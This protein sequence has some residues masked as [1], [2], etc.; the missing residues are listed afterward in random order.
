MKLKKIYI[1]GNY[2]RT[3]QCFDRFVD[4]ELTLRRTIK[5]VDVI[6][7]SRIFYQMPAA[8]QIQ[9]AKMSARLIEDSDFILIMDGSDE[10][11]RVHFEY[12]YARCLGKKILFEDELKEWLLQSSKKE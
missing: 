4:L 1:S 6:N 7:P 9:I 10:S 3:D 11:A 5:D 2:D 12:S 8:D